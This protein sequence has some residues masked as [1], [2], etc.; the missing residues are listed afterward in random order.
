MYAITPAK[1]AMKRISP[2]P[3]SIPPSVIAPARSDHRRAVEPPRADEREDQIRQPRGQRRERQER[4]ADVRADR[5]HDVVDEHDHD[6]QSK[7]QTR[8]AAAANRADAEG[9][10]DQRKDETC[11]GL[12]QLLL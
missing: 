1:A 3:R 6:R 4:L 7:T 12:R 8:A 11:E 9:H 2:I 10:R 5:L